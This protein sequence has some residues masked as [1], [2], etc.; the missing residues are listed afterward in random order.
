MVLDQ[1]VNKKIII[2]YLDYVDWEVGTLIGFD[3]TGILVEVNGLKKYVSWRNISE[4]REP[5]QEEVKK[6]SKMR[7][8]TNTRENQILLVFSLTLLFIGISST[9]MIYHFILIEPL[10]GF[11]R[12]LTVSVGGP[13]VIIGILG[14][15]LSFITGHNK[16]TVLFSSISIIAVVSI[17]VLFGE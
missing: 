8:I 14:S 5:L 16:L 6:Q 15:F 9:Y 11:P 13:A 7:D 3:D 12:T 1:L 10:I 17:I 2:I 4:L